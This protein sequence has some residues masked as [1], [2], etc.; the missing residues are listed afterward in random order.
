LN[1]SWLPVVAVAQISIQVAAA[2][3]DI[4]QIL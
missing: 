2:P 3:G 1:I 4:E